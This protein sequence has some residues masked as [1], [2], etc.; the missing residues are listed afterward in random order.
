L[1][2]IHDEHQVAPEAGTS[3]QMIY[4]HYRELTT[5]A[6]AKAWFSVMPEGAATNVVSVPLQGIL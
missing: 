3:P 5:E 4:Q 6:E 2:E 1:C